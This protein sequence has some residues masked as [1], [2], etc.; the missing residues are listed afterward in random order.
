MRSAECKVRK[1]HEAGEPERAW[2]VSLSF[3]LCLLTA[4]GMYAS[5]SLAP[6]FLTYLTLRHQHATNRVELVRLQRQVHYL[7]KVGEALENEPDFAAELARIDFD[8]ARPG[9]ERIPVDRTL[10]L[11][12]RAE[13]DQELPAVTLPW[14]TPL[15]ELLAG[16]RRL[17]TVTLVAA[18]LLTL[19]AFTFLHDSQARQIH[20][21]TE[22]LRS[23]LR[24]FARRY[25]KSA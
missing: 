20:T 7:S 18:A 10:S 14:Y 6:K 4:A 1:D 21:T 23:S 16:H 9:D 5:V 13:P 12:A 25:R 3:W 8:A 22:T 17:R 15:V 2:L 19:F 24:C 11:D